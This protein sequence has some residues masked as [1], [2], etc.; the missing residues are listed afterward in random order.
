[1]NTWVKEMKEKQ[2]RLQ[3]VSAP[4][5]YPVLSDDDTKDQRDWKD[6]F[7]YRVY[8]PYWTKVRFEM[9]NVMAF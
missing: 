5:L 1:M 3:N 6:S 8:V 7:Q 4:P 2:D 9:Y